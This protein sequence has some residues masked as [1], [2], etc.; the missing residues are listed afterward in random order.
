MVSTDASGKGSRVY[1]KTSDNILG[2][3]IARPQGLLSSMAAVR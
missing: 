3:E 2:L 1:G